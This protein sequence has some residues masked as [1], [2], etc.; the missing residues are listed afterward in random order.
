[1]VTCSWPMWPDI[2]RPLNTRPGKRA[3]PIEPGARWCLWLPWLAPWPLKLWRF[4]PPAKPLPRLTAVTSTLLPAAIE[5]D[6]DL[7]ADFEAV[8]GVEAQF[9]EALPGSNAGLGEVAG[10]RAC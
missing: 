9:D 7:L 5:V 6:L 10:L 2:F 4:M 8:D 3:E 1:M